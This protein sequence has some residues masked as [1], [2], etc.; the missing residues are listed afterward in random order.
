[1]T[2]WE[3]TYLE[4]TYDTQ[5]QVVSKR[6]WE[7]FKLADRPKFLPYLN[8]LGDRDWEVISMLGNMKPSAVLPKRPKSN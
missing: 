8:L 7:E 4:I 6:D 2:K 5:G 3:Y 1:M